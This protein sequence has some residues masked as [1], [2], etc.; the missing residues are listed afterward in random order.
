VYDTSLLKIRKAFMREPSTESKE[1]INDLIA[2][3]QH[4]WQFT[5]IEEFERSFD[6]DEPKF[7]TNKPTLH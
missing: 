5:N 1:F 2:R 7:P 6:E 3:E 4:N